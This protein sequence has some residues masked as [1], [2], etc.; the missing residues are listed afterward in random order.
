MLTIKELQQDIG[1]LL[2]YLHSTNESDW[3][4]AHI[5]RSFKRMRLRWDANIKYYYTPTDTEEFIKLVYSR[6]DFK[7]LIKSLT[8]R[9][10]AIGKLE[11]KKEYKLS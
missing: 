10:T 4:M 1:D 11:L 3:E 7:D 5:G 9:H 2:D 8:I 6:V